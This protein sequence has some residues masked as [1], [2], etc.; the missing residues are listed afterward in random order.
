[1]VDF[2]GLESAKFRKTHLIKRKIPSTL[3]ATIRAR[4]NGFMIEQLPKQRQLYLL[5]SN[6]S[7]ET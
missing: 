1:M 3:K 4:L 5:A 6:A 2:K 7:N